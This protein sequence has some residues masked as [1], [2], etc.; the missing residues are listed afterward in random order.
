MEVRRKKEKERDKI[1]RPFF[2]PLNPSNKHRS[3]RKI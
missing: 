3:K 1:K 2:I